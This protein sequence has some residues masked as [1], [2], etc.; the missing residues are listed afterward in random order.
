MD[1]IEN[2]EIYRNWISE[3]KELKIKGTDDILQY[4]IKS[5]KIKPEEMTGIMKE[6]IKG[7]LKGIE[8]FC[9]EG[10]FKPLRL[11]DEINKSC[12]IIT[13]KDNQEMFYY[14][15]GVYHEGAEFMV[16]RVIQ[17]IL[18]EENTTFRSNE[19]VYQ[20]K[21]KTAVD[22]ES[23][24]SDKY[25]I[26][27]KNGIFD[28]ENNKLIKHSEN[29]LS[30][31]QLPIKYDKKA[32]CPKINKFFKQIV[33]K[34]DIPVLEEMFGYCLWKDYHIQTSFILEGTGAN[35]KSTYLNLLGTF[36]GKNNVS[37]V[38]L[39]DLCSRRFSLA[40]VYKKLANTSIDLPNTKIM[41]TGLFKS[42][43][44]GD[45]VQAEKKF[46]A[47]FN[48]VNFA[49]MIFSANEIP[50]SKDMTPAF[51]RRMR[52]IEF[53][54]VFEHKKAN[55]HLLEELTTPEELSG[56]FNVALKGLKRLIEKG[57]F[58]G[59]PTTIDL[60]N[61]YKRRSSSVACFAMDMLE[62]DPYGAVGKHEMYT[63]YVEYCRLE[64]KIE[65]PSN[66]FG[67]DLP[68]YISTSVGRQTIAGEERTPCWLGIMIKENPSSS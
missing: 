53:P 48:F 68:R 17:D 29:I 39:Q 4:I 14:S 37:H 57:E 67:R 34:E 30:L 9:E 62:R 52:I 64:N 32:K 19:V 24:D 23:I 25:L 45:P 10:K 26:N 38:T 41:E 43:T 11:V 3:A 7:T 8:E 61:I 1:L 12:T 44:G 31:C 58:T 15:G 21:C 65:K 36:L 60:E 50:E 63:T 40:N 13:T 28:L 49:K 59:T 22:R 42:L 6:I 55:K 2:S 51:F 27:L 16:R 5:K 18:G 35:G 20:L 46:K 33:R 56:L 54:N 66:I 47:L